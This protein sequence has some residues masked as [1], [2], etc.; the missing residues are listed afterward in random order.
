MFH[1]ICR[2]SLIGFTLA[3][4]GC[5]VQNSPS[6]EWRQNRSSQLDTFYPGVKFG[7]SPD[8]VRAKVPASYQVVHN[9]NVMRLTRPRSNGRIEQIE[10]HF[11]GGRLTYS[12]D[13]G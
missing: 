7:M 13:R 8:E 3:F 4:S 2:R 6:A 10:F 9:G 12:A 1:N 5:V 11:E